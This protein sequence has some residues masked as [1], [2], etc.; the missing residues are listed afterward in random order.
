MKDRTVMEGSSGRGEG[1]KE[2]RWRCTIDGRNS[3]YGYM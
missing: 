1:M 3:I 2:I